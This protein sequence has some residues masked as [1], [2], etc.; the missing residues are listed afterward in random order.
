MSSAAA[1][2]V[3][4]EGYGTKPATAYGGSEMVRWSKQVRA[5]MLAV[6]T[7]TIMWQTMYDIWKMF[8]VGIAAY[9]KQSL[10][11]DAE[12]SARLAAS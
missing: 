8:H 3:H 11:L 9:T 12:T 10:R 1:E 4:D 6:G 7:Y 2:P 5:Y